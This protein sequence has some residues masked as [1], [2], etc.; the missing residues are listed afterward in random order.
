MYTAILYLNFEDQR[1]TKVKSCLD[2]FDTIESALEWAKDYAPDV[3]YNCELEGYNVDNY[4]IDIL[5]NKCLIEHQGIFM[6]AE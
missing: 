1:V 4:T 2:A 5:Q 3:A 6:L